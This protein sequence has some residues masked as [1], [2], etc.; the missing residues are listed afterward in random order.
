MKRI[1]KGAFVSNSITDTR[2][3]INMLKTILLNIAVL[4]SKTVNK[5]NVGNSRVTPHKS[6]DINIPVKKN[7]AE[8][9]LRKRDLSAVGMNAIVPNV[10]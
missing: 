8:A 2:E 5:G 3:T 7:R 9:F 6:I 1:N 4:S 10:I